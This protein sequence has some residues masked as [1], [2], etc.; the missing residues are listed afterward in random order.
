M[1]VRTTHVRY[2]RRDSLSAIGASCRGKDLSRPLSGVPEQTVPEALNPD[3]TIPWRN[4]SAQEERPVGTESTF[5]STPIDLDL[6]PVRFV[7]WEPDH[8]WHLGKGFLPSEGQAGRWNRGGL[9]SSKASHFPLAIVGFGGK[10]IV[11]GN[12]SCKAEITSHAPQKWRSPNDWAESWV[13]FSGGCPLCVVG[14][15]LGFRHG[16][17]Y[18]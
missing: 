16:F 10:R 17:V 14:S 6:S 7:W 18:L 12:S 3:Q 2:D 13:L 15:N 4:K 8:K 1:E 11:G 5:T 9:P